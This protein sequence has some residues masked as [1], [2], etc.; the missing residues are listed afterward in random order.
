TDTLLICSCTA[1][2]ILLS[3]VH[4]AADLNGIQLTQQ[5][6]SQHIGPWASIFVAVAIFLFAFSSL[7]GN[8]YYGETNI[9]FL[10]GSKVL[11]TAYRIAVL[12]M[13]MLGSVATIQIVWDVA[14]LFMGIM[15]VINLVAIVFLSKYAFAALSDYVK[16][17]KQG[18]DPVF[19]ADS[20]PGLKN[21]ECWDK[22]AVA[23]KEKA[24]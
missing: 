11:L 15:A 10:N 22:S 14:D 16:Q 7:V 5:A 23:D 8:Y 24:V 2:I 19:Y 20:I 9:E 13:V 17:K 21:T 4:N 12:G 3:D 6:L 1:F 18:K